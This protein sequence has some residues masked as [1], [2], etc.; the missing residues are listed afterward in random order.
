LPICSR[1][2]LG[3]PPFIT[4][5][6]GCGGKPEAVRKKLDPPAEAKA[7]VGVNAVTAL[8]VSGDPRSEEAGSEP[9]DS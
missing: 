1:C 6:P 8:P 7:A 5:C 4:I 9:T 2:N 3:I